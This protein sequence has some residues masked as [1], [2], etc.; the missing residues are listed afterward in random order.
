MRRHLKE[1]H[2]KEK[3]EIDQITQRQEAALREGTWA[4]DIFALT[5]FLCDGL[6][7][8]KPVPTSANQAAALRFFSI[9]KMGSMKQSILNKNS[10][11]AFKSL[12]RVLL[13][14]AK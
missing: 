14:P 11:A 7:Q 9:A 2:K 10:E 12:A 1:I 4:A 6:L 8:L 5:V 3:A 13:S